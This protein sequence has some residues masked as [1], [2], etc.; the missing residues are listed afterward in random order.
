MG[1]QGERKRMQL[2]EPGAS[3]DRERRHRQ[4]KSWKN[5]QIRGR[6]EG[7]RKSKTHKG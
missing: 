6:K 1:S 3:S 2:Q 5:E 4:Q 7:E